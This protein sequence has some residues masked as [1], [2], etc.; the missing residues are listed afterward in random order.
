[1]IY[2]SNEEIQYIKEHYSG[3]TVKRL[4]EE[5][6]KPP[7]S[8]Y[9]QILKLNLKKQTHR[10]WGED[11]LLYIKEHY[12]NMTSKEMSQ[13]LNRTIASINAQRDKLGLVRHSSWTDS[14]VDFLKNNFNTMSHKEIGQALGR[15]QGAITAKCFDLN[16]YKKEE[17]WHEWEIRFVKDNYLEMSKAEIAEILNRSCDAIQVR[18]NRLG[19]KKS[20]YF[21]DYHYFD[22]IDTEDKAYWFGFLMADGWISKNQNTGSGSIGISLQYGDIEHLKKFNKAILGNY[23][24]TD[25]WRRCLISKKDKTKKHHCCEIRIYSTIM[26]NS[27]YKLGFTNTKTYDV[28]F[29]QLNDDL[30]RHYIRGYFDGDGTLC[31]TNK[32]FKVSFTTA[33]YNLN[34]SLTEILNEQNFELIKSDY[35]NENNTMIYKIDIRRKKDK[36]RFLK[37]IYQDSAVYLERKYKKFIRIIN[38]N[39]I[40]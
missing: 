40:I 30:I 10:P 38:E 29:L 22:C 19:L 8:V 34:K 37:W 24:I 17:P 32:S 20:P 12:I 4:S 39:N 36:I 33:S 14:E 23:K 3:S 13:V 16:L 1:M 26:Y 9:N 27:L 11:E 28:D 18:A 21:C 7:N 31:Y 35:I 6:N 2:F 15:T 5:L 25:R